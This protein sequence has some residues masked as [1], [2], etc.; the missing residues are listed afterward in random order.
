MDL[1]PSKQMNCPR[2]A[3]RNEYPS[4]H[5]KL[6]PPLSRYVRTSSMLEA[7]SST[8]PP[9]YS[10][11]S[12]HTSSSK[13]SIG[14][15]IFYPWPALEKFIT[16]ITRRSKRITIP[17]D[18]YTTIPIDYCSSELHKTLASNFWSPGAIALKSSL[19][20]VSTRTVS[21]QKE[22]TDTVDT[23]IK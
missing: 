14:S 9:G 22:Y 13:N 5:P 4:S 2:V 19:A 20:C 12:H 17:I 3:R 7:Y 10:W 1:I 21:W 15:S 8:H 23:H 18:Y 11:T 6:I 16:W